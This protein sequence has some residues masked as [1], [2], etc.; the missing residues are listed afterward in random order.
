MFERYTEDARRALFFARYEASQF[1][2][3]VIETG[4]LLLGLMREPTGMVTPVFTRADVSLDEL[5][6]RIERLM[7]SGQ[8]VAPS[9]EIPFTAEVKRVL[10][11]AAAEADRLLHNEIDT[12]HLLLGILREERCVAAQILTGKGMRLDSARADVARAR[13]NRRTDTS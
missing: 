6:Q 11:N 7:P 9:V 13:T 8:K 3:V 2:S 5:R 10:E 4:H 1:G 12:G